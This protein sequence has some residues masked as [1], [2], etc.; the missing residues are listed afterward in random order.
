MISYGVV[1]VRSD[2]LMKSYLSS[3]PEILDEYVMEFVPAEKLEAW[4][5]NKKEKFVWNTVRYV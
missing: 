2:Q 5:K 3:H 1:S 4:L